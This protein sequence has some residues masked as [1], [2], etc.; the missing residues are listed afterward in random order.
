MGYVAS[1]SIDTVYQGPTYISVSSDIHKYTQSLM[2]RA[3]FLHLTIHARGMWIKPRSPACHAGVLT[4]TRCCA[5]TIVYQRRNGRDTSES[6]RE[7]DQRL[8]IP[9]N[10]NRRTDIKSH[11]CTGSVIN[12]IDG[13]QDKV[14]NTIQ[15][16]FL[17]L[18]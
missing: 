4:T 2:L 16:L 17:L 8:D 13:Y 11:I 7:V 3:R 18:H 5:S 12:V 10:H 15:Y 14:L 6:E 1:R 9:L